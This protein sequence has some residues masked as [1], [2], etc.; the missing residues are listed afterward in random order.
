M[1]LL[2]FSTAGSVDDG[3]STLIGRLLHDA[4]G[5]FED[6][7]EAVRRASGD[8]A[9]PDLALLTD[10]LRAEREQGITID[11]AYRYFATPERKFIIADTPGHEQYTRN[12]AT[13]ASTAEA[14]VILV[15]ARKGLQPQSRRHTCIAHLLGIRHLVFA[16]NK[17]DLVDY[18]ADRFALLREEILAFCEHL[19]ADTPVIIPVSALVGDNVVSHGD[20][21]PWYRGPCLLDH[22]ESIDPVAEDAAA[23]LRYPVQLV[24]RGDDDFR[25]YAGTVAT[26]R[27]RPGDRVT[28]LPSGL[29]TTVRRIHT[30]DGPLEAAGPGQS[31]ALQLADELDISRGDM[32]VAGTRPQAR[33]RIDATLIWMDHAPL[34]P[35][36][37]YQLKHATRQVRTRVAAV[38]GRTDVVSLDEHPAESLGLNE[39]GRVTLDCAQPL[40]VD[41]YEDN[42][43]T[44]GFILID[45][46]TNATVAAGLVAREQSVTTVEVFDDAQDIDRAARERQQQHRGG[47][48]WLTGLPG[49]GKRYLARELERRLFRRG[50]RACVLDADALRAGLSDD[51]GF[52]VDDRTENLRRAAEVAKLL[53]G[54]GQIVIADFMTPTAEQRT[55]VRSI[56]GDGDYIE[57]FVDSPAEAYATRDPHGLYLRARAAEGDNVAS[58]DVPYERPAAADVVLEVADTGVE[59]GVT[60]LLDEIAGRG[61]L[62]DAG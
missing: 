41:A 49:T 42:R 45:L 51:L 10:G 39:I 59:A 29:E 40:Q 56:V 34:R 53:V 3:K 22:L 33:R 1:D 46:E 9:A 24:L 55:R 44:G 32:L 62:G 4:K 31:V 50:L 60:R 52:T 27:V 25:G 12:M 13:G 30:A 54:T 28:A 2:R 7:L 36:R 5:I 47:V 35:G 43:T 14:S 38:H 37:P 15:D 58:I 18:D 21:M 16:V 17:M 23:A 61:W 20:N 26:G 6:Q 11:V 8:D 48:L 57:V 19:G